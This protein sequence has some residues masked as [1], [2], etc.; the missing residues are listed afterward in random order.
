MPSGEFMPKARAAALR[1]IAL[2]DTLAE[3]HANLGHIM[4][5]YDW[6][7]TAAEN[8]HRR[9]LQLDPDS[10]D[11]LQFYAHLLSSMGRHA[12]ALDRIRRARELDPVNLRVN[13]VEG[14]LL[15]HAGRTDEAV[16]RL[17]K[18]LELDPNH[19]LANM[20]AA[21]A[22]IEKGMFAVAIAATRKARELTE[23]N[24]EPLAYGT[25]ALARAG[26]LSH[27]NAGS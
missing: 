4:F 7:W 8:Q 17:Q 1:A 11:A 15:L 13:A 2:D 24:S 10:P 18:T 20:M 12:E 23:G 21:R 3:A 26:R 27:I 9:A 19:R 6:D 22:Y 14:M 16:A 5:W 25:Y